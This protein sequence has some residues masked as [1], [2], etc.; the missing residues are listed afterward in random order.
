MAD[1][2]SER[3]NHNIHFQRRIMDAVPD[4]ARTALDIGT[5]NGLLAAELRARGLEVTAVDPDET[6]LEAA[7]AEIEGVT[8]VLGDVMTHP[9]APGSFDVVASVATLHHL[10]D[11]DASLARMAELAA[12]G[13]VVAAVGLA[14]SS[15]PSDALYDIVGAVESWRQT[16]GRTVW[17][18]SAPTVWPPPHT[19]YE[20]RKAAARLLP[21]AR[22]TRLTM[23]RYALVW[24]KPV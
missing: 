1:N 22:W 3:W 6:V 20:V 2:V 5:G 12:P 7:R 24:H 21:G 19:Y 15:R 8:W 23:W 17:E 13:G 9:F 16:R 10:S 14:R 4:S 11:L 18:H